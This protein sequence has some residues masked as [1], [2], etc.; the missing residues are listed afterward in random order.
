MSRR[1]EYQEG[2]TL[3]EYAF[4]ISVVVLVVLAG[5]IK[6]GNNSTARMDNVAAQAEQHMD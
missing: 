3:I 4:L 5:I 1:R 6:F 2:T